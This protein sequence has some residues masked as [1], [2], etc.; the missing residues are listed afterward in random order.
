MQALIPVTSEIIKYVTY[1]T[2]FPQAVEVATFETILLYIF[3][4]MSDVYL[5][6]QN[7]VR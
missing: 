4:K 6:F 2:L 7:P 3:F 1:G 5:N